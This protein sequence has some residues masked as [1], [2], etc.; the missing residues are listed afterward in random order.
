MFNI[1]AQIK[2][3]NVKEE[4]SMNKSVGFLAHTRE[5]VSF[6]LVPRLPVYDCKCLGFQI[7]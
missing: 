7:C 5:E 2:M 3:S 6:N 1:V 4:Q